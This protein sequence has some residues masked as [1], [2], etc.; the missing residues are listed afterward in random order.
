[1]KEVTKFASIYH[2]AMLVA[3]P[4]AAE[5]SKPWFVC[6][7]TWTLDGPRTRTCDGRWKTAE[8][9]REAMAERGITV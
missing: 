9:A 2:L 1:M 4:G 7:T 5:I 8:Q 3:E 6:E